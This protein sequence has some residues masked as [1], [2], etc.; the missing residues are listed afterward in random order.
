MHGFLYTY[1]TISTVNETELR[2]SI[3][4]LSATAV[5]CQ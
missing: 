3:F 1:Y 4:I 2:G 5:Y